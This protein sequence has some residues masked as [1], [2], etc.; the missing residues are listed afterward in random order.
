MLL[1]PFEAEADAEA[2][3]L[4]APGIPFLS[5]CWIA[6]L[7]AVCSPWPCG[8]PG[9][10]SP[11]SGP[12]SIPTRTGWSC[13]P[14]P[15]PACCMAE[16]SICCSDTGGPWVGGPSRS[17]CCMAAATAAWCT[18]R[19]PGRDAL[20]A[21]KCAAS[22]AGNWPPPVVAVPVCEVVV[23][24]EL[25][26][27]TT[28]GTEPSR[29]G[30]GGTGAAVGAHRRLPQGATGAGCAAGPVGGAPGVGAMVVMM[31]TDCSTADCTTDCITK[32]RALTCLGG[33]RARWSMMS[34]MA[35]CACAM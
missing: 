21:A 28:R 10:P 31:G 24:V 16:L 34:D 25:A 27:G 18:A 20:T 6:L 14:L 35:C 13:A 29:G 8:P 7:M 5:A 11:I 4:P 26:G 1:D 19:C 9:P 3:P 30:T 32:G 22:S 15:P 33:G 12:S 23:V 2:G 17:P